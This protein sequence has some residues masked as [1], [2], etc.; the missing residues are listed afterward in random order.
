MS[1]ITMEQ[2]LDWLH[3]NT[4]LYSYRSEDEKF[5]LNEIYKAI[6]ARLLLMDEWIKRA[7]SIQTVYVAGEWE[8]AL[9]DNDT[10]VADLIRD[11]ANAR[12]KP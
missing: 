11:I 6:R 3:A 5:V 7:T 9:R 4:F 1:K 2:M 8:L 12:G 10:R